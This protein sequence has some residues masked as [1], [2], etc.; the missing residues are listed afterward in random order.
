MGKLEPGIVHLS[1]SSGVD[2][3]LGGEPLTEQIIMCRKII[4]RGDEEIRTMC[5]AWNSRCSKFPSF[6]DHVGGWI[7]APK[8]PTV[9]FTARPRAYPARQA[10]A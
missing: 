9:A 1:P 5:E 6:A 3:P 2:V 10:A 7:P 8:L 4:G